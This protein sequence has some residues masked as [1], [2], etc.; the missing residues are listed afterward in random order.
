VKHLAENKETPLEIKQIDRL[1]AETKE[2]LK[3]I[4]AEKEKILS[5]YSHAGQNVPKAASRLSGDWI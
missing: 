2:R 5:E 4:E 3:S 1:I